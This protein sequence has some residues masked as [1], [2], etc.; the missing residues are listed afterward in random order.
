[1]KLSPFSRSENLEAPVPLWKKNATEL[2][3]L[4]IRLWSF[5]F[6]DGIH[7]LLGQVAM[8]SKKP[9]RNLALKRGKRVKCLF[10]PFFLPSSL[11]PSL[12]PFFL[13]FCFLGLHLQHTEVSRLEVES[14]L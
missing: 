14:E 10:L 7:G 2:T 3:A 1:M 6:Q 8:V 4:S 12:L 9:K 13:P 11:P 5:N